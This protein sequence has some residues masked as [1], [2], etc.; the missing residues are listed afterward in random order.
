MRYSVCI[1]HPSRVDIRPDLNNIFLDL[2]K[3]T[4]MSDQIFDIVTTSALHCF[5]TIHHVL[6]L[7]FSVKHCRVVAATMA[8]QKQAA[9]L[10]REPS[11]FEDLNANQ[12][13]GMIKR[14]SEEG[15]MPAKSTSPSDLT[16]QSGLTQLVICVAGIYASL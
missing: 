8:R 11:N 15:E 4:T 7:S 12:S 6:L 9:P 14:P 1:F 5:P 16:H 10:R 13:N 2:E 3:D